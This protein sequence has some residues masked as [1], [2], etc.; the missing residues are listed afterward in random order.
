MKQNGYQI[1]QELF[2][3]EKKKQ[4]NPNVAKAVISIVEDNLGLKIRSVNDFLKETYGADDLDIMGIIKDIHISILK[5]RLDQPNDLNRIILITKQGHD[6]TTKH[7]ITAT[8]K[9]M[10]QLSKQKK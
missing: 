8:N 9:V 7:L 4:I 2:G 6:V 3:F 5:I 10:Q 1:I